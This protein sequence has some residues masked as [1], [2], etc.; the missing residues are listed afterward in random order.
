M[1]RRWRALG[2]AITFGFVAAGLAVG[3][4][5][6]AISEFS[7]VYRLPDGTAIPWSFDPGTKSSPDELT[8]QVPADQRIGA[9]TD[10][11]GHSCLDR[12]CVLKDSHRFSRL[13]ATMKDGSTL[14]LLRSWR[15]PAS[16]RDRLAAL[17]AAA[18]AVTAGA[19]AAATFL[20]WDK[21]ARPSARPTP[22]DVDQLAVLSR[23]K[24][25]PGVR[26][27]EQHTVAFRAV[28]FSWA[29][30]GA[31][32][33][34]LIMALVLFNLGLMSDDGDSVLSAAFLLVT[35]PGA[36]AAASLLGH[37]HGCWLLGRLEVGE[38]GLCVG[39][40]LSDFYPWGDVV[41][42]GAGDWTIAT[43]IGRGIEVA[44]VTMVTADGVV[45]LHPLSSRKAIDY[46]A[47]R[48]HDARVRLLADVLGLVKPRL[49]ETLRPV[50]HIAAPKD[51]DV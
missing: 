26:V 5:G 24:G 44:G 39:R 42:I 41:S 14:P 23:Q 50:T 7:G 36:I 32:S 4:L 6:I 45:L 49:A 31:D 16:S 34:V 35:V 43:T 15:R 38:D 18:S 11:D 12:R 48:T 10:R 3:I 40:W 20:R 29:R 27:T 22:L 2:W 30:V 28:S 19:V 33:F 9:I 25:A 13:T 1:V 47:R 21:N 51:G 46:R 37:E 8:L 17:W